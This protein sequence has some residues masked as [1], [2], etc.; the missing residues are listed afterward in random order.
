MDKSYFQCFRCFY[1]CVLKTDMI[2]HVN[3]KKL[4]TRKLESYVYSDEELK[5]KSLN[6]IY[7]NDV[8]NKNLCTF[9]NKDF[10]SK[11]SLKRH[12]I[13]FCKNKKHQNVT[14][15]ESV[16]INNVTI[17]ESVNNIT[18]DE[19]VNINIDNSVN[20]NLNIN[21]LTSFDKNWNIEHIDNNLKLIL[22]L[23]NSKFTKTLE[24][25]L[26]NKSNLNVLLDQTK[27]EGIVFNDDKLQHKDIKDILRKSMDKL[28]EQLCGFYTDLSNPNILDI[29]INVLSNE[30]NEAKVKY[31]NYKKDLVVQNKVNE[32]ISN[33]YMKQKNITVKEIKHTLSEGY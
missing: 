2:R 1:K 7:V 9:C 12:L 29:N 3:K 16:N 15:D 32:L 19:S 10:V 6:R 17:D 24:N 20:I 8:L 22:L 23:N 26:D 13:S 33:I 25:I 14:T 28:Y 4:C 31:N 11:S 5:T 18:I 30:L 27:K 21:L